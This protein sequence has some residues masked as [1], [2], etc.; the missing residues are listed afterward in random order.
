[1]LVEKAIGTI[2]TQLQ[3]QLQ[4]QLTFSLEELLLL[5]I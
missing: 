5:V 4:L 3:L 1:M 2:E